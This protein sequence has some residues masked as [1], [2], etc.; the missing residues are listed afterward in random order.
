VKA[1]VDIVINGA[2][3]QA[4]VISMFDGGLKV[5]FD[6]RSYVLYSEVTA[7]GLKVMVSGLPCFFPNDADPTAL[8]TES[9][10]KLIGFLVA[11]GDMVQVGQPYAEI[12]V[13]KT[14]MPLIAANGPG[15]VSLVKQAG[16]AVEA[17]DVLARLTLA[18]GAEVKR[19]T[20][21][22]GKFPEVGLNSAACGSTLLGEVRAATLM[23]AAVSGGFA[24][25]FDAIPALVAGVTDPTL[26][27][28]E[29]K[30]V[31]K[32]AQDLP[33][34]VEEALQRIGG[35]RD[36]A[37]VRLVNDMALL[38]DVALGAAALGGHEDAH[39]ETHAFLTKYACGQQG[40]TAL[41]LTA[42]LRD[43][44]AV[45]NC[46]DS[47]SSYQDAI[48]EL[49]D[50]H[51]E[52]LEV[53]AG[54]M[55][56]HAQVEEKGRMVLQVLDHIAA[57]DT[58]VHYT[59]VLALMSELTGDKYTQ[60]GQRC[61]E[62]LFNMDQQQRQVEQTRRRRTESS[63]LKTA[64]NG[65]SLNRNMRPATS[66]SS[67]ADSEG[68]FDLE[69]DA[70]SSAGVDEVTKL[71]DNSSEDL[72]KV[73]V[74]AIFNVKDK[75]AQAKAL[76]EYYE[77]FGI[78]NAIQSAGKNQVKMQLGN[79]ASA[80]VVTSVL[81]VAGVLL[82]LKAEGML[83][84]VNILLPH[85][86][87]ENLEEAVAEAMEGA[88]EDLVGSTLIQVSFTLLSQHRAPVHLS[89]LK[90][91][92]FQ[93]DKVWRG[94]EPALGLQMELDRLSNF[95][96]K[97]LSESPAHQALAISAPNYYLKVLYAKEREK[98][99]VVDARIFL[100]ASVYNCAYFLN[101][102][103]P[104]REDSR[105]AGQSPGRQRRLSESGSDK[106][107]KRSSSFKLLGGEEDGAIEVSNVLVDML[108]N[109]ELEK[110]NH[111]A[112]HNNF[113][114]INLNPPTTSTANPEAVEDTL[115][116]F[117]ESCAPELTRLSVST[118]EVKMG[119]TRFVATHTAG[120]HYKV[121]RHTEEDPTGEALSPYSTLT[122]MQRK[123]M[124]AQ[125]ANSTYVYDFLA[126]FE[127]LVAAA[128]P[129]GWNQSP[130]EEAA[131]RAVELVLN[132]EGNM[133]ETRR[134]PGNN[135]CAM[136]VFRCWMRTPECRNGREFVLVGSDLSHQSGSFSLREDLVYCK[137]LELARLEGLPCV[138]I[139]A[140]SGA[141][142]SLNEDVKRKL[143]VAWLDEACPSK[144]FEYVYLAEADYEELKE[145]VHAVR[146]E[147]DDHEVRYRVADV[148]GGYG[149]EC[150]SGSGMIATATSAAYTDIVTVS[151]VT[152]RSVG[153]G[154][155]VSRLSQRIIQHVDAPIIL[156]GA[157]A[158]NKVLG[159]QVYASNG[160]I[161]GPKVMHHNGV[162]H[163]TVVSDL[164][165]CAAI[166]ELL[167]YVP[168]Y[169][170]ATLPIFPSSDPVNRRVEW[171]PE[172]N[173]Y[174]PRH[175]LAGGPVNALNPE[176]KSKP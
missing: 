147:V 129:R 148:F 3:L 67:T 141:R 45:E 123:K 158:L 17:G 139:S 19:A 165:G 161:G 121:E 160:Q 97:K 13:M 50:V 93:E 118:V 6:G 18:D 142:I 82:K 98:D 133:E 78:N 25:M 73:D 166:L 70:G 54:H 153:I 117:V 86:E 105:R 55:L 106:S 83:T 126:I 157:A 32:A 151:Y 34:L 143:R 47:A 12:E 59:H 162:T 154:A 46:F 131:W 144:G 109:L 84:L 89:Y 87:E 74:E 72:P 111:P 94:V 100:R 107:M 57:T 76:K 23:A 135:D 119:T 26:P 38:A 16:G 163:K 150:L 68:E 63:T 172:A 31:L 96:V 114:F 116:H 101:P 30:E 130:L 91:R 61:K 40:A 99:S 58:A 77:A 75:V 112:T 115:G 140:N 79:G 41:A 138:Y 174:D 125:R 29:A 159:R 136:V 122:R 146:V 35:Y 24:V 104:S 52:A 27:S 69:S 42:V 167:S 169:R 113:M 85:D 5:L 14:V 51:K 175:M 11:D 66:V 132:S 149:V 44:L 103:A 80:V 48:L 65:L 95:D 120:K 28:M 53:V 90:S 21:F 20:M 110:S 127:E 56:S 176:K 155:Y 145:T 81:E 108:R 33:P 168:A 60:V 170:G 9:A 43:Y 134:P 62:L 2:H 22:E 10:G 171:M 128:D 8:Q 71:L 156:T 39:P 64:M 36:G 124:M 4:E 152:G 102:H 15:R 1:E 7:T 92:E 49:R 88:V 164:E 173:T 137:A 37:S